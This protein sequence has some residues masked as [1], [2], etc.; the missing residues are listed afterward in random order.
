MLSPRRVLVVE[1]DGNMRAALERLLTAA[2]LDC[3]TY[4]SAEDMLADGEG[5]SAGCVISDQRLP[6]MSGLDLLSTLRLRGVSLP[7]IMIT[8]FDKPGQRDEAVRRGAS[9]YLL[10]P[11]SGAALI[12]AVK[13][14]LGC[15]SGPPGPA[16]G[17]DTTRS[18]IE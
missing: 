6:A 5:V 18:T 8:A 7:L 13:S 11:F 10:K 17:T 16:G 3:K 4:G 12:A 9:A 1:D 15:P 2:G 14:A